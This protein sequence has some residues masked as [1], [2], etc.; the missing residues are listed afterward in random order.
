MISRSDMPR[1]RL[2]SQ[3]RGFISKGMAL[4]PSFRPPGQS[5]GGRPPYG[6][7]LFPLARFHADLIFGLAGLSRIIRRAGALLIAT[8]FATARVFGPRRS[9]SAPKPHEDQND[10]NG[11]HDDLLS[12]SVATHCTTRASYAMTPARYRTMPAPEQ[13][14]MVGIT[15]ILNRKMAIIAATES[16][17]AQGSA[18]RSTG[19]SNASPEKRTGVTSWNT[20][21]TANQIARLRTTPTTAAVIAER[22][23]L[24]ALLPRNTSMN[25]APRKIQRKHGVNVTQVASSPPKVPAS[26]GGSAPGLRNAPMKP[27]NCS[28]MISGPGVVSAIPSPSSISPGLSQ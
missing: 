2:G 26:I 15:P 3:E 4:F 10:G 6:I 9:V 19:A 7:P 12:S 8:L 18:L 27:T 1:T 28:T 22:A 5:V 20:V 21:C 17:S 13:A 23:P 16:A 25:G 24:S 11:S 14:A